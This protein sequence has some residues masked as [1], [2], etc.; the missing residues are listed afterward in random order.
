MRGKQGV[1]AAPGEARVAFAT[2]CAGGNA[3]ACFQAARM[4]L[5]DFR[6]AQPPSAPPAPGAPAAAPAPLPPAAQAALDDVVGYASKGCAT[7]SST[8]RGNCC[9]MLAQLRMGP[10]PLP[11][12]GGHALPRA[13]A[14]GEGGSGVDAA[15]D[16]TPPGRMSARA[17]LERACDA[18]HPASCGVLST[19][20]RDGSERLGIAPDAAA[21]AAL[22]RRGLRLSGLSERQADWQLR[23]FELQRAAAGARPGV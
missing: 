14:L 18:E 4:R 6:G 21:A 10:L 15:G 23:L 12:S 11:R 9:F 1:D 13:G 19:L 17:L 7:G 5:T 22:A 20:L 8:D 16:D 3:G 2:A